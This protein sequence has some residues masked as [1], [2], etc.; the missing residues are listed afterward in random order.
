MERERQIIEK[1][2]TINKKNKKAGVKNWAKY[3]TGNFQERK[4]E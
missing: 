3:M 2:S 1:N 4:H